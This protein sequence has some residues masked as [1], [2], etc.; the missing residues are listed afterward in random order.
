MRTTVRIDDEILER[1]QDRAR[2]EKISLTRL[3]NRT[4]RAGMRVTTTRAARTT[5]REEPFVMGVPSL[6]LDKAMAL[7]T[8]LEDEETVRELTVGR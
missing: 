3:L 1:L 8:V 6:P 5:Y 2:K 4:L 7:A